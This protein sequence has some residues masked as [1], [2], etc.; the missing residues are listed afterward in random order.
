MY[1]RGQ[2]RKERR[3]CASGIQERISSRK[4]A[5][6]L[7][8]TLYIF[9]IKHLY[10][11]QI[12]KMKRG[13]CG[14]VLTSALATEIYMHKIRLQNQGKLAE[15]HDQT[16]MMKGQSVPVS[17]I[18]NVSAKTIRDIWNRRTWTFATC[19]LWEDEP[20]SFEV[21]LRCAS[22]LSYWSTNDF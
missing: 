7:K 22:F 3:K 21:C 1:G 2:F 12:A 20:V 17:K 4:C 19:H 18:Y 15:R 9:N 10:R 11:P 14:V 16:S 8:K 5:Y 6:N 13:R